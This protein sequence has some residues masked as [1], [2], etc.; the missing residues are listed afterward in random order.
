[1][2][3]LMFYKDPVALNRDAHKTLLFTAQ[4]DFSFAESINSV[5][6]TG[7]EFFEA[8]RDMPVLFS[9]DDNGDFFPLAL[10]SLLND[11]HKLSEQGEWGDTYIPA[12]IR[13]YPFALTDEGTVCFD[14]AAAHFSEQQGDALFDEQGENSKVLDN[15]IGFLNQFDQQHKHTLAFCQAAKDLDMFKPFNI[16][17]NQPD[18]DPLRLQGLFALDEEKLTQ[19]DKD[20]L[21][22]WFRK[23][24][25]AW[26]YAHMHSLG[27]LK[28]LLKYQQSGEAE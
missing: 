21:N 23:G 26:S 28:R 1:M 8:S 18:T 12:F 19:L 25:L 5:P 11:Q 4:N 9:Q 17:V 15:A 10:L 22:D 2:T 16:Q 24:W 6:L 14:Q 3:T 7:I 27:A 13:R 20:Q